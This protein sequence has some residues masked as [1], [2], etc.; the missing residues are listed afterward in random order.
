[1][2]VANTTGCYN[3]AT[4]TEVK[5]FKIEAPA[6][7]PNQPDSCLSFHLSVRL[8]IYL[9]VDL[10]ISPFITLSNCPYLNKSV[11]I[12]ASFCHFCYSF[13]IFSLS[14]LSISYVPNCRSICLSVFLCDSLSVCVSACRCVC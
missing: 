10:L 3:T 13:S 2:A 14:S 12:F 9:F 5:S 1:M 8:F 7:L 6:H 4:F 11:C